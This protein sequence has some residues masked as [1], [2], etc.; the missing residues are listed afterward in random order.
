MNGLEILQRM[1]DY[2]GFTMTFNAY[3][4]NILILSAT[5]EGETEPIDEPLFTEDE[6][7]TILLKANGNRDYVLEG[8]LDIGEVTIEIR[9][10][11][12]FFN[13]NTTFCR[14]SFNIP[15]QHCIT[16]FKKAMI[17]RQKLN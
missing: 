2:N 7:K 8:V 4:N 15:N 12:T 14:F 3:L 1:N 5:I 11:L 16:A 10:A 6:W 9:G 13:I 17:D